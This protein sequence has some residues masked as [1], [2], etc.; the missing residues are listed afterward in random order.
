MRLS[1]IL[2]KKPNKDYQQVEGFLGDKNLSI[3]KTRKINIGK[4]ALNFYCKKCNDMRTFMSESDVH[5]LKINENKISIDTNLTCGCGNNIESWFVVESESNILEYAPH[6]K[7]FKRKFRLSDNAR[8]HYTYNEF[9]NSNFEKADIAYEEQLGIASIMY[10]RVI[11]EAVVRE[12]AIRHNFIAEET[13]ITNFRQTL[14]NVDN[15]T[16]IVP[17]EFSN[18]GYRLYRELSEVIHGRTTECE[19]LEKYPYCRRLVIGIV[20]NIKNSEEIIDALEHLSWGNQ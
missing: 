6:V 7:V 3:G 11:L 13:R 1:D 14:E 16:R 12:L 18:D 2:S 5:C 20:D 17:R 8:F 4:I 15:V 10:L 19:A 9:V